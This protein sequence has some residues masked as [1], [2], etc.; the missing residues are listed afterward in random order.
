MLSGTLALEQ[1][2]DSHWSRKQWVFTS[3]A[4]TSEKGMKSGN[5]IISVRQ[6]NALNKINNSHNLLYNCLNTR[7]KWYNFH[8]SLCLREEEYFLRLYRRFDVTTVIAQGNQRGSNTCTQNLTF[9]IEFHGRVEV[10][11][12]FRVQEMVGVRNRLIASIY[13]T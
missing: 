8:S 3:E 5:A 7:A 9:T 6:I 1:I 11:P 13:R 12:I 10:E 2:N 4:T